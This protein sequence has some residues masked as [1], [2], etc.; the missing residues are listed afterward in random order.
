MLITICIEN[1]RLILSYGKLKIFNE[2]IIYFLHFCICNYI[3]M[4]NTKFLNYAFLSLPELKLYLELGSH[5]LVLCL[6]H[7]IRKGL[8]GAGVCKFIFP[9]SPL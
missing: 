3:Y 7:Q 8:N 6:Y 2:M 5:F 9:L 4:Y 1:I